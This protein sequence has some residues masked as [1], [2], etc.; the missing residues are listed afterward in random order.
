MYRLD[1]EGSN[2]GYDLAQIV[3]AEAAFVYQASDLKTFG[4]LNFLR[5]LSLAFS[6]WQFG[7]S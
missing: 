3:I 4:R 5:S 1:D 2:D 6:S 7:N